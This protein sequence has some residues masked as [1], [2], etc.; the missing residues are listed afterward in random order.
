M[1]KYTLFH[2]LCVYHMHV[3][4]TSIYSLYASNSSPYIQNICKTAI[5]KS[6]NA[7]TRVYTTQPLSIYL[8]FSAFEQ[9]LYYNY[10]HTF[11]T[12]IYSAFNSP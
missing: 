11:Y 2:P 4:I 8:R 12:R 7:R 6:A 1:Y 10:I 3:Y 5:G 9:R